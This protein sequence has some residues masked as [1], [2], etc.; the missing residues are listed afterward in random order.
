VRGRLRHQA[1]SVGIEI[2]R[3][4]PAIGSSLCDSIAPP[5]YGLVALPPSADQPSLYA[6]D[7]AGPKYCVSVL[8]LYF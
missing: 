2:W 1:V 3:F 5:L 4:D 6:R 7:G 8:D